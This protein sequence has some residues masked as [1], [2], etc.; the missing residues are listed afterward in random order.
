MTIKEDDCPPFFVDS[1]NKAGISFFGNF[2]FLGN[3]TGHEKPTWLTGYHNDV[4]MVGA[5]D[6]VSTADCVFLQ[7]L[8]P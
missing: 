5:F 7:T 1:F 8:E 2:T 3:G 4:F 6:C